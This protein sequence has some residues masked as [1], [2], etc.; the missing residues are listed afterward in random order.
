VTARPRIEIVQALRGVAAGLVVLFH[1]R[2]A[3]NGPSWLDLGDRLFGNGAWG[4][5]L[6]FLISGFIMVQVTA[7]VAG[8]P[9]DAARFLLRRWARVW[10]VYAVATVVFIAVAYEATAPEY[11][12]SWHDVAPVG[13]ALAFYPVKSGGPPAFGYPPLFVGWSLVYEIWFYVM[14]AASLLARRW[15]WRVLA[16]LFALTLLGVPLALRGT[17]S[18]G[19][20]HDYQL[21]PVVLGILASPMMWEFAIGVLV[22]L[23]YGSRRWRIPVEVARPLALLAIGAAIVQFASSVGSDHGPFACGLTLVPMFA[24]VMLL[25]R[26]RPLRAPRWLVWLGDVS[27]SLYLV[28]PIIRYALPRILTALGHA[29]LA[30]GGAYFLAALWLTVLVAWASHRYLERGLAERVRRALGA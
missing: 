26:E 24:A 15:R 11:L 19:V 25:D 21:H 16:A 9:R 28:H 4:V 2:G 12:G 17:V 8:T 14:F 22:G 7:D 18:F 29:E 6:F 30:A 1:F 20:G 27:F 23:A 3:L 13:K 10:P 5:D